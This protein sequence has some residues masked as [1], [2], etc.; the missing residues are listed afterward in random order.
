MLDIRPA[1]TTATPNRGISEIDAAAARFS[2]DVSTG[3]WHML[4]PES[5][6][7]H[8][9]SRWHSGGTGPAYVTR[10]GLGEEIMHIPD[11]VAATLGPDEII[12]SDCLRQWGEEFQ[13]ALD[14]TLDCSL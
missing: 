2:D 6:D 10:C 11:T 12:C 5:V 1:V 14:A 4:R 3:E 8:Y 7:W 13:E 9:G